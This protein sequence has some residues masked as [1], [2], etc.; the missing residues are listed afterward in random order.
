M[1]EI[2]KPK[3]SEA[4]TMKKY[5]QQVGPDGPNSG[6]GPMSYSVDGGPQRGSWSSQAATGAAKFTL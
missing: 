6:P 2:E 3:S 5:F 1:S 4:E